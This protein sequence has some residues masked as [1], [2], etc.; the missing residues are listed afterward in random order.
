MLWCTSATRRLRS[1]FHSGTTWAPIGQTPVLEKTGNR[2]SIG[3]ISAITAGGSLKFGTFTGNV[4]SGVFIDFLKKLVRDSR[5]PVFLIL[6][7]H[8]AH[9]AGVT[10]EYVNSPPT[11]WPASRNCHAWSGIL[12]RPAP[13]IHH[14][15]LLDNCRLSS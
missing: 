9:T 6:D 11:P 13:S 4:N 7:R 10:T 3:M 5:R 12:R 8:K 14:K 2:K 1:D 15:S